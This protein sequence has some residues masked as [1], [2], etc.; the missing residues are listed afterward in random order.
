MLSQRQVDPR[1]YAQL[2][3]GARTTPAKGPTHLATMPPMM[4]DVTAWL[5]VGRRAYNSFHDF[6]ASLSLPGEHV[7]DGAAGFKL[8]L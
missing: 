7:R 4:A 5:S 8:G 6:F 1:R 3:A 2:Q